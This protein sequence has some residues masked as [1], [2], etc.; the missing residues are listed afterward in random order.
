MS[1]VTEA[2]HGYRSGAE[3]NPE[4]A[5]ARGLRT[6][7]V[8]LAKPDVS[9]PRPAV[10]FMRPFLSHCLFEELRPRLL[11]ALFVVADNPDEALHVDAIARLKLCQF[12]GR[13]RH[14][15]EEAL[16]DGEI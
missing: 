8:E 2:D 13:S 15:V 16:I 3:R 10:C 1:R 6:A 12:G 11:A 5:A 7:Q 4:S 14:Q 9:G